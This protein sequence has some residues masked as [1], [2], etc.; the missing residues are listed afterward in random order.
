MHHDTSL[1]DII[2]VGLAVAFVLGT[3]AQKVKLSP[4]VG[5]LLAGVCVGPFTPG[6]VADQTMA[7]QLSELGVMLLMFGVGLHFSLDDL[8]EV[9]WIAVPGALA[10]IVV[11][12][13]LGWALAWS[14]GWPLMQGLVFGLALSVASTVVLLRALE[15]RRLLETQRGRIAVGWLIVEDLV[16]VIA[17]VLL[18]A[19]ANV[20]GGSAGAA[21]HAGEST[22][23]LAALGW[24]LLKMVAFV[25][26]MLVVGRRVIPW[27]LEKVAATGSRELFTLA[28]LGIALGVAFGSAKLFGVSF[29]LGAFFAGM[30]LKESELSHKA[31][32]DSL[33]LRDAFA[34]LFF[35]SVGMLFD[36]MILIAHPWQ[37]LATFL[38]VTVGKSLA[39]FVIVR[40]FGHPTG[41]ALTIS[42]SLA[43]IG[44]FSFILAG[45]GVQ[46]AILPET[47]RDL[48]LAGALLSIVANPFLFSWLDR[49]QAK[50]AQEAPATVEP[51]LPPGPPLQLDGH[52]IV[53]GYGRVGSA[54]AQLLRSRGVP[55]LVIDD[56][57]DHVAKAHAAGIPGIRGS[58]AADRV[59][60]EARPEQAKIAIL[61]IP[62]PLEAGEALA[63]LRALNPSLTLLARA[64]S[65]AEVKHLLEHG[66][67]GAVLAE[68]ELAY[69]LAEMVMSTP[70]YRALRVPAS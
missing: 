34:V 68:R 4:L 41:T 62:Q 27:S 8:M 19:L 17:L 66:A 56:N 40:A 10:Q 13:L 24:T 49:W 28:V 69:S 39:A 38:T 50:Q 57:G 2:A 26:V 54:L 37:V 14:M 65:D 1:I 9:K 6:F 52:A 58:A 12:T 48:I 5:Y 51:D 55:V 59:L 64:H 60:A 25:A 21:E 30:L 70:P 33:P 67:D 44:E 31:A 7:N 45:L 36:P 18:P 47:G 15:E 35:V 23:L 61:A 46:L 22:S 53:I 32:S 63:K 20:L 29:A 42:T 16:M 43:Q 11:A 3:L